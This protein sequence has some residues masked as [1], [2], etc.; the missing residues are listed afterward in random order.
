MQGAPARP[1]GQTG[2]LTSLGPGLQT[3]PLGSDQESRQA[4][5]LGSKPGLYSAKALESRCLPDVQ[6]GVGSVPRP[7]QTCLHVRVS[8]LVV[9]LSH[10]LTY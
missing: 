6:A 7:S 3:R 10:T 4:R 8:E 9:C 5:A 1:L 2:F